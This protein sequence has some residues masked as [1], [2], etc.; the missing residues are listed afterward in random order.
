MN[1]LFGV[2]ICGQG[3]LKATNKSGIDECVAFSD[4]DIAADTARRFHGE[5]RFIDD[6]LKA[7]EKRLLEIEQGRTFN[8]PWRRK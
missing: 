8:L 4:R 5:V 3:W 7:L 2:W 1:P 6:S